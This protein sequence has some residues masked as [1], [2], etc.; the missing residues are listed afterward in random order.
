MGGVNG[1]LRLGAVL[2]LHLS[3]YKWKHVSTLALEKARTGSQLTGEDIN[4]PA[5]PSSVKANQS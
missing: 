5:E 1:A 2:V 4:L 3:P